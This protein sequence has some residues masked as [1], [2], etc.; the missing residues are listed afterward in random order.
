VLL[1]LVPVF[2]S[3][4]VVLLLVPLTLSLVVLLT[5]VLVLLSLTVALVF[6]VLS[7]DAS[8]RYTLTALLLTLVD[9]P[10]RLSELSSLCTVAFLPVVRS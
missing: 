6:E 1:V 4:V 8:G 10:E 7:L 9:L 3:F 2:V 5:F